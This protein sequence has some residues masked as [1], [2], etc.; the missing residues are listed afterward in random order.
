MSFAKSQFASKNNIPLGGKLFISLTE[1]DKQY[2]GEVGKMFTDLGFE[3][4]AT[5][6]THTVLEAAG[7]ASTK[8]I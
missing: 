1:N 7:V 3:I 2:A 8:V 5:S 6:G 4:V